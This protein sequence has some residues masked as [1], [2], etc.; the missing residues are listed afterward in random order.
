MRDLFW[1]SKEE[2]SD[3]PESERAAITPHEF[4]RESRGHSST[5][6]NAVDFSHNRIYFYSG[7]TRP[8]ILRLNKGIFNLN[9]NMISKS[10]PLEYDPPPI[11]LHINSYGGSVF[12]GLS[13]VDYIKNSK[14]PVHT[15]ID[16]C[17]A[18]A[19]TLMSIVGSRR[20]M[21]KNSC[22]LIHQLSG[23][24]WGKFQEMQD[25]M[26]NSEM[27]MNKIKNIYRQHTKIPQ[28]ELDNILKHDL[29]WEAEK[30]LEYGLVDEL[31]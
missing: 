28:E 12:A 5:D 27:L 14:I 23:L 30:C 20:Y 1:G 21:H 3:A 29:W 6:N 7:V 31:I 18:S 19:A 17:A 25:D 24:M 13:A 2:D 8:K 26:Q 9:F 11:K 15:I 10:T 16:G 22:M 4:T